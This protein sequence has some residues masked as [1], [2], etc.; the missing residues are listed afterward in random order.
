MAHDTVTGYRKPWIE[1][2]ELEPSL[3]LC[4]STT[5]GGLQ[6]VIDEPMM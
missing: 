3:M 4:D 5:E 6:D 2:E 1:V